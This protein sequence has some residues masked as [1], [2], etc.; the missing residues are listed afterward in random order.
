VNH[1]KNYEFDQ[2]GSTEEQAKSRLELESWFSNTKLRTALRQAV[3]ATKSGKTATEVAEIIEPVRGEL[4]FHTR[5]QWVSKYLAY[6]IEFAYRC[7]CPLPP[8]WNGKR[9]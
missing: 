1:P 9:K 6:K 7:R 3:D 2:G 5:H 8:L 4:E